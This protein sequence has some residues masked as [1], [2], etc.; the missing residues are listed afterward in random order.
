MTSR[1]D[2]FYSKCGL[3]QGEST[4]PLLF[5]IFVNDLENNLQ[6]VSLGT[7]IQDVVIQLLLFADDMAL[8]SETREG[9][10]KGLDNLGNYCTK[11][12]IT[13]NTRKTKVVV[14]RKGGKLGRLDVWSYMGR[15]IEVV[16][17]F[18]Y[19]GCFLSSGGSFA[20]CI[21]E[22][23]NSARRALFSVKKYFAKNEEILTSMKLKLFDSMV[24]PILFYCSEVWGCRRADPMEKFH[25]YF[26]KKMF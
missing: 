13:V 26:L 12:G 14:F 19:L 2:F 21:Q 16:T 17:F 25:L 15:N 7:R 6:D 24:S 8:F 11:W 20:K 4:S 9:L 23:T 18:K 5:S 22:L 1:E 10:Q 3:L